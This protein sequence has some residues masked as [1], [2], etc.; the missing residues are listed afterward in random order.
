MK[1][2]LAAILLSLFVLSGSIRAQQTPPAQQTVVQVECRDMATTGNYLAPNETLTNGK[3]C[4]PAGTPLQAVQTQPESKPTQATAEPSAPSAAVTE[5]AAKEAPNATATICFYRPHRFEG[6]AL[7][8]SVYV[9]DDRIAPLHNGE[10]IRVVV[11]AG[12]HRLYSNDKATGTNLDAEPGHTYYLRVDIQTGFWKGHG[13]VTLVDPQEGQ[14]ESSQAKSSV[15]RD[16]TDQ[17]T[18]PV[19]EAQH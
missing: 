12:Q 18:A 10:S 13:A 1:H 16:L 14:Y 2:V 6:A 15:T 9:D 3:A 4:R 11:P 17:G 7:K 19:E 5:A 8:P